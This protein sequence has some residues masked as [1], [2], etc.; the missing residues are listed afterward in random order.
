MTKQQWKRYL[1]AMAY[2]M[3]PQNYSQGGYNP[4][5]KKVIIIWDPKIQGYV[6]ASP[7]SDAFVQGLKSL[8]PVGARHWDSDKKVWRVTEPYGVVIKNIA[9]AAFGKSSVEFTSKADVESR[10]QKQQ[11]P[12]VSGANGLGKTCYNFLS[13]LDYEETKSLYR[14]ALMRLHPD[15]GGSAE[16]TAQLNLAWKEIEEQIYKK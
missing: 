4:M 15:K 6:V 1:L 11:T 3:H 2:G 9:E 12:V 16:K 8:I 5:S 13:L 14:K 7:Y 10:Q